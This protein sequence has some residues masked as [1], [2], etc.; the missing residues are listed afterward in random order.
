[1]LI[2]ADLLIFVKFVISDEEL[3]LKNLKISLL[4]SF[5]ISLLEYRF[6]TFGTVLKILLAK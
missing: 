3:Y 1:M 5:R 2:L 6:L 4:D